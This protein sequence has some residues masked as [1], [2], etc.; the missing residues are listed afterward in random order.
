MKITTVSS[1]DEVINQLD[2]II[3]WSIK[4]QSRLGYFPVLYKQV[5]ERVKQ[6]IEQNTFEEG[7]R[8]EKL[9]VTFAN[10]YFEALEE[11]LEFNKPTRSWQVAFKAS[12]DYWP[13]VIQHL[14]LGINA[15]INLDL[16]IAA[17]QTAPGAEIMNLKKDFDEINRIL[18]EMVDEV[19]NKLTRIWPAMKTLDYLGG[20][21]DEAIVNF[22]I[23]KARH[24]A[25]M[26]AMNLASMTESEQGRAIQKL[27]KRIARLANKVY[28]PGIL[29]RLVTRIVRL[30]EVGS[31]AQIM[32]W[33]Q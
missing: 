12:Q 8:M 27:D 19:Q 24:E 29:L 7:E 3:Q 26:A 22:S 4:H 9:D 18:A 6:G 17:A 28:K 2:E 23:H 5:T 30:R 32:H 13:I 16:G 31:P 33:L 25:W 14:L 15:H 10:R 1:I 11:Y 20:D 21:T